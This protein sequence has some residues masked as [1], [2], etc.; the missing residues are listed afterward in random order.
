MIVAAGGTLSA[1]A[2]TAIESTGSARVLRVWVFN[3]GAVQRLVFVKYGAQQAEEVLLDPDTGRTVGPQALTGAETLK[4]WQETGA[5][6]VYR[7]T[8][9]S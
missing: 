6:V 8:G 1:V 4:A 7:V 3:P 5:D 9:E 2:D